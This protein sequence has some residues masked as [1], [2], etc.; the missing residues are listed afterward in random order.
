MNSL[1]FEKCNAFIRFFVTPTDGQTVV[2]LPAISFSVI[3]SFFDVVTHPKMPAHRAVLVDYL[4]SGFSDHPD[5]FDYSMDGH[6]ECVAAVLDEAGLRETTVV[7]HSMGGTVA[8]KLALA[9]PD[10]VSKL[11]VGEGNVTPGGGGLASQIAAHDEATFINR[12]YPRMLAELFEKAQDGDVI[13][14]RRINVWKHASPL[15]LYRNARALVGVEETLMNKFLSMSIPRTFIY[16][17]KSVPSNPDEVGA[18]TPLPD[19]LNAHGVN[20]EIVPNAGHGQMF[21]NLDG[22]VDILSRVAV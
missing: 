13:G 16:G 19:E 8:I 7:G 11:I 20:T 18:D 9:R 2:Y 15:G 3:G 21:D 1:Y 17:E 10:L 22:F 14:L 5:D 4:G 12:E 6:A